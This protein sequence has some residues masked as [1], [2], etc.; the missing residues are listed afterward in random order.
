M[1]CRT[2]VVG[3]RVLDADR[4]TVRVPT[5][6]RDRNRQVRVHRRHGDIRFDQRVRLGPGQHRDVL[7]ADLANVQNRRRSRLHCRGWTS[8]H[9]NRGR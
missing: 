8:R 1:P 7:S 2:A 4:A 9:D 6:M 5:V 3:P